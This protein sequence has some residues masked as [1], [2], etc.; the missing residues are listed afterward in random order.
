MKKT[1]LISYPRSGHH[2]LVDLL[3]ACTESNYESKDYRGLVH[4]ST[5][6]Y[7][8]KYSHCSTTYCTDSNTN[9]QKNHDFFL[10]V[11]VD[12]PYKKVI[13]IR[14]DF[15][16][17]IIS[18]FKLQ[19]KFYNFPNTYEHWIL[20]LERSIYYWN[21]FIYKW[22]K[23]CKEKHVIIYEDLIDHPVTVLRDLLA[24]LEINDYQDIE[25][26]ISQFTFRKP[27]TS[28]E[29]YDEKHF[30]QFVIENLTTLNILTNYHKKK[31][32]VLNS[33]FNRT[34]IND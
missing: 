1:M 15:I 24:Y 7:C 5:I 14:K 17:S 6:K 33:S 25:K 9:L 31:D 16:G 19:T 26:I 11:D 4:G 13:L 23:S 18:Y 20:F 10:H 3:F 32:E 28:F 27:D 30:N 8:E 2:L 22:L 34:I 29:F 12:I 21:G